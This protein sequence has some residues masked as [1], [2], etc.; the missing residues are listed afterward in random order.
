MPGDVDTAVKA[1]RKAFKSGVWSRMAPRDRMTVIY[2]FAKLIE[3]NAL[4]FALLDT[5]DMG[6]PISDMLNSDIPGSVMTFQYFGET[7][8][9]IEGQVTSTA[10]TE[11]HYIL[12]QPLGV[13]GCIV[14]G[15]IR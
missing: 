3:E 2:K 13:V 1:A 15:T 9:K 14:P 6:K 10:A 4:E 11:F 8:D 5:I 12:R 7:I